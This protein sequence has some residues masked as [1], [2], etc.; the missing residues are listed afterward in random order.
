MFSC[1]RNLVS[2]AYNNNNNNRTPRVKEEMANNANMNVI[3][4][5]MRV[6]AQ[7]D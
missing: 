7:N 4:F 2:P 3:V 1:C 6:K 5:E